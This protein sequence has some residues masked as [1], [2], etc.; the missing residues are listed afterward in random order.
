MLIVLMAVLVAGAAAAQETWIQVE[1]RPSRAEAE[2][3]A[4]EWDARLDDVA[5]FSTGGRWYAIVI[6]PFTET[7]ARR[8]LLD[9]RARRL[10]PADSF[11]VDGR[12]FGAQVYAGVPGPLEPGP[13]IAAPGPEPEP[14]IPAEE[15]PAQARAAERQLSGEDRRELQRAL[16]YD[17]FYRSTIDGAFG[18]GT[19]RAIE[20]WQSANRFEATG[21]LTSRQRTALLGGYREALASLG[22]ATVADTRAGV[23]I[24]LPLGLLGPPVYDPPFARYEATDGS[25]A[26]VLLISQAGDQTALAGLYDIL[27]TL[28]IVPLEGRRE[29]RR[30][31]F[32][33]TGADDEIASHS[34]AVVDGGAVKGFTLVWPAD[35]LKRRDLVLSA[36]EGSFQPIPGVLPDVVDA[37]AQSID[38]VA[39]LEI[40]RPEKSRSGFYVS[41]AGAVVTTSEVVGAC[42]RITFGD[43]TDADIAAEDPAAG[44]A[45]LTPRLRLSPL[46]VARL[47][48]SA[49]RLQSEVAVAGYSFG[50]ALSAPTL[51]YGSLADVRGLDGDT[52]ADRL[53]LVAE[54]GDAGGPVFDSAGAVV[55][56]LQP[57]QDGNGRVLPSDVNFATDA[58]VIAEFLSNAGIAAAAADAGQAMAPE[59]LTLLAA[60]MTVLVNCWN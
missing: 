16:A 57:R 20:S 5:S 32:V 12:G 39:G 52:G 40:R 49:P 46:A 34:F 50:G 51:T 15:T 55:G 45:L 30:N 3:R 7:D 17:G 21:F 24:D 48:P 42:E 19:R 60:D 28:E 23:E 29:R 38:L 26:M 35:D 36:L 41:D 8:R 13:D 14:L 10:I 22:L 54:P 27:Q 2:A 6:G 11:V 1:A 59:D 53:A 33:L 43:E 31:S 25:G 58:A 44:L 37:N 4:A 47:S 9:L 56:M 18:P